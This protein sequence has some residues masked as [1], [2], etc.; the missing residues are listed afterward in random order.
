MGTKKKTLVAGLETLNSPPPDGK[1]SLLVR[2]TYEGSIALA[3]ERDQ[4]EDITLDILGE[5]IVPAEW[6]KHR[7]LRSFIEKGWVS[8]EW[9]D[10]NYQPR[11]VPDPNDAPSDLRVANGQLRQFAFGI[12]AFND[13][14]AIEMI[15]TIVY[16]QDSTE[17]NIPYMRRE[18]HSVLKLAEW[19]ESKLRDRPN[20]K[21]AISAAVRRIQDL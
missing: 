16:Q 17:V 14:K 15:D 5:K 7:G 6:Q 13:A 19:L 1:N 12:A 9:V 10:E 21:R 3:P 4:K 11:R 2:N 8:V 18:F 20:V